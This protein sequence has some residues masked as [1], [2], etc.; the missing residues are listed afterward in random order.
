MLKDL[1]GFAGHR[2][3]ATYGLVYKITLTGNKD[4]AVLQKTVAIADARS[5]IDQIHWY[6]SHYTPYIQQQGIL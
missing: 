4:H 3:K 5:K 2:E 6:V 1:F